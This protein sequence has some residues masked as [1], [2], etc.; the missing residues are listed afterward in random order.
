MRITFK[1]FI[2]GSIDVPGNGVHKFTGELEMGTQ[3]HYTMELQTCVCVPVEDGLNVYSSTQWMHNTQAAI[4]K[5]LDLPLNRFLLLQC[6]NNNI[7]IFM[8]Q[9]LRVFHIMNDTKRKL[10]KEQ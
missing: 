4:A 3:Y 1:L 6:H 10:G 8:A 9:H 5:A 7:F 2:I